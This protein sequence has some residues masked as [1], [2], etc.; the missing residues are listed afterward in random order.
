MIPSAFCQQN[1]TVL[2]ALFME[3]HD[4]SASAAEKAGTVGKLGMAVGIAF[5]TGPLLGS[6]FF[7][8]YRTAASFAGF[9][10]LG[11][12][13]CLVL[14]PPPATRKSDYE[15]GNLALENEKRTSSSISVFQF[16]DLIPNP[17]PSARTPPAVFL[18]ISRIL[19][20]L[21]FHVF[22]TIWTVALRE[23]FNFGPKD[24]GRYYS[25]I[26]L[27]F[28]ISQGFVAKYLVKNIGA[29]DRGRKQLLL[30][31]AAV[32][33]GGRFI[34][35][36][37]DSMK[38]VYSVFGLIV[39]ALGIINTIFTADTSNIASPRE[40]GGLFGIL[41]SMESIAGI[42]GPIIGGILATLVHPIWGPLSFVLIL[43]GLVFLMI[44]FGYERIVCKR[45]D[46]DK[47]KEN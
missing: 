12:T 16:S 35:Y 15:N 10:L 33:G 31:C 46:I 4:E 28:A 6:L 26:G 13:I 43:Y 27:G 45:M 36:Q 3:Y 41:S 8:D 19:M 2:K 38:T 9:C 30:I 42:T 20:A 18:M 1:F 47:M 29:T 23:R 14:L 40:L 34:A 39:T 37:T 32:L 17:V 24:Y 11:S 22:Q 21:A 25:F 7:S 44:L 5:M